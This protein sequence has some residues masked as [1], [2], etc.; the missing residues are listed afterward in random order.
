MAGKMTRTKL[1]VG[2]EHIILNELPDFVVEDFAEVRDASIRR[3]CIM[4]ENHG[5]LN[6]AGCK[7][8]G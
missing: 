5:Q 1:T 7:D 4:C 3:R 8:A 6:C 2:S